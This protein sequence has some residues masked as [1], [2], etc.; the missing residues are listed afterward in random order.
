MP[1]ISVIIPSYRAWPLIRQTLEALLQQV[2]PP[3]HEVLVVD[4]G[5]D[6][7]A[8]AVRDAFPGVQVIHLTSQTNP[9]GARNRGIDRCTGDILAFVDA[10]AVPAPDWLQRI[11]AAHA[12]HPEYAAIGGSIA[13]AHADSRVAQVAHLLEFSGYTPTWPPRIA[14][15]I[16]TCN[17]SIKRSV[18]GDGRFLEATWGNEDVELVERLRSTGMVIWFDPALQVAHFSK[19]DPMALIN[20]QR[21]LGES[22][23]QVRRAYDLP[24]SWLARIPGAW[25]LCPLIKAGILWKRALSHEPG[26]WRLL[27]TEAPLI[28]RALLA[29]TAGFR[30]GLHL[31]PL[32]RGT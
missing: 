2:D 21:K 16:P 27:L 11:A 25:L 13:N 17:L 28:T 15:V 3:S 14:R 19:T 7:T 23:A 5:D 9:G 26:A 32:E 4:S 31:P 1:L 18:L 29:W 30:Q 24:G 22:T 12:A 10:D 6:N 20:Q 8:E